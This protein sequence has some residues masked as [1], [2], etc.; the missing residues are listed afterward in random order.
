[1]KQQ[2]QWFA[3]GAVMGIADAV[4]GVSGG[5]MALITGIYERLIAALAALRLDTARQ[6]W[7]GDW[8]GAWQRID[9]AFL[10]SLGLGILL[11]LFST[12]SLMHFLLAQAPQL[13]WAFFAGL[14]VAS[15]VVLMR[16]HRWQPIDALLMALGTIIAAGIALSTSLQ[17][18]PTPF[19]LVVGGALAISAMLLPGVSGS[20]ILLLLGIYPAVV[21]AVSDVDVM[22]IAWVALGC[23]VGLLA[24]SR[25]LNALLARWHDR[26]LGFMLG[27]VL[28]ALIKV[29]PW[30][31][32]GE[33]L[34]PQSYSLLTGNPAWLSGCLIVALLGV[35]AVF[36]LTR[37]TR[38]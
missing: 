17:L 2:L 37:K 30:Q 15:L 16:R 31:A 36:V 33:W 9:G 10:L 14:I 25:L 13:V 23:L 8:A 32:N 27:F 29:W 19:W 3:K 20:F 12:L 21:Q 24:F 26:V 28:G 22:T 4:P 38:I 5:T 35:A 6:A 1:M 18:A 7:S 34:R 11:S